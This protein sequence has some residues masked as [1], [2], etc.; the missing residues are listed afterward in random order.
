MS[1]VNSTMTSLCIFWT[2]LTSGK[3]GPLLVCCKC[4]SSDGKVGVGFFALGCFSTLSFGCLWTLRK[5]LCVWSLYAYTENFPG[6]SIFRQPTTRLKTQSWWQGPSRKAYQK[7][8]HLLSMEFCAA[9][10]GKLPCILGVCACVYVC[11]SV[12]KEMSVIETMSLWCQ[13]MPRACG[14]IF[15]DM[16]VWCVDICI[17][18][19]CCC[20]RFASSFL[21]AVLAWTAGV[22]Y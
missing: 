13:A 6:I 14:W 11:V 10:L 15:S 7:T 9:S 17:A 18:F 5:N 8:Q 19:C 1:A 22:W 20:F 4:A 12:K 2:C 21:Q 16:N 3:A